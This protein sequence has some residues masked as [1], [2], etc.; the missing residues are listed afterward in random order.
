[1]PHPTEIDETRDEVLTLLRVVKTISSWVLAI[2]LSL[3]GAGTIGAVALTW[4]VLSDH[5]DQMRLR[6]EM[7]HVSPRLNHLWSKMY[8]DDK[9]T[10]MSIPSQLTQ[11]A[12]PTL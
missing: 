11:I 5:Y 4:F 1:M 12:A 7:D 3:G 2:T 8:P 9:P 10:A 6:Q